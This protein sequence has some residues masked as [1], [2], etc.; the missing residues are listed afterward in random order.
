M[1]LVPSNADVRSG[2]PPWRE[3]ERR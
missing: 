1:I 3:L 2:T